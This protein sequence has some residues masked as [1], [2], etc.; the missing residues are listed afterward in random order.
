MPKRARPVVASADPDSWG[1]WYSLERWK[2]LR[3]AQLFKQ[4]CCTLCLA[5]GKVEEAT[6][7]HHVRPHKGNPVLFFDATN[8]ESVCAPHHDRDLQSAEKGGKP[9]T[10]T[11]TVDGWPAYQPPQSAKPRF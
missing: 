10:P 6:V 8:L 1:R 5:E 9:W 4:P 3:R 11:P 7:V 2:R